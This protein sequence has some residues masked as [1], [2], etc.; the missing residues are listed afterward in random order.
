MLRAFFRHEQ[1]L[2]IKL[3]SFFLTDECKGV[4]VAWGLGGGGAGLV[5][6]GLDGGGP[7][8]GPVGGPEGPPLPLPLPL[9]VIVSSFKKMRLVKVSKNE[10]ELMSFLRT[11]FELRKHDN[12]SDYNFIE[13]L[14]RDK[15]TSNQILAKSREPENW[16]LENQLRKS[17]L[18]EVFW[19]C[20]KM[21]LQSS[22]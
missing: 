5:D 3:K 16:D 15:G 4:E 6:G 18:I 13:I 21:A 19:C 8:G 12:Q 2:S 1:P 20:C 9:P 11:V 7:R 17:D 22:C 10:W 14:S